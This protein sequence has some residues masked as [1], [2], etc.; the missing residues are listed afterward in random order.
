[1]SNIAAALASTVIFLFLPPPNSDVPIGTAFIF[2]Y[3]NPS[4]PKQQI[5]FI[6]TAKHVLGERE[7]IIGRFSP[8][9]GKNP[10]SVLYDINQLKGSGDYFEH[11]DSGVDI[12]IFRTPHFKVADYQPLPYAMI[13]SEQNYVEEDIK[14]ADR[15]IFPFLLTRFMG[16]SRNYPVTRDGIIALLAA[17]PAPLKYKVGS[18]LIETKQ[19]LVFVDAL[20]VQGAS[21]CPVFLWPGPRLKNNSFAI[22]GGKPLLLGIMH[23]F[24]NALPREIVP[25]VTTDVKAGFSENSGIA[26]VFPSWRIREIV[27]APKFQSRLS[28]LF[29]QIESRKEK[30]SP[31]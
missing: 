26:I 13:A 2:G 23:G 20:S 14:V 24:Y 21:G 4:D 16:T 29:A 8:A 5:P 10:I 11:Q 28:E 9:S 15:V 17:E 22:G 19:T 27:E 3:P 25:I 1:M 6:V 31:N 18:R 30:P 7:Q 12:A